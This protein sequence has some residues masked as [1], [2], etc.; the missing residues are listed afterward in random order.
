MNIFYRE[1]GPTNAPTLLPHGFPTSSQM[2][3]KLIP[4]LADKYHVIA[5]DYPGYSQSDM[6][7]MSSY[8]Y[9]FD[10]LAATIDKFTTAVGVSRYALYV[11]DYGAP[12]G[13]RSSVPARLAEGQAAPARHRPFRAGRG[14]RRHRRPDARFFGAQRQ[15]V[16]MRR[17]WGRGFRHRPLIQA[18]RCAVARDSSY[19]GSTTIIGDRS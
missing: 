2:F 17:T 19:N 8:T 16:T 11:Q 10:N 6:P 9:S 18:D 14:Q 5:P 15:A 7:A 12:V 13:H 3:R 4:L 1:A